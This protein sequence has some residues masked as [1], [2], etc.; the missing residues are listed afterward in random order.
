[1]AHPTTKEVEKLAGEALT[2]VPPIYADTH[3]WETKD[4]IR[5]IAKTI[6]RY[7]LRWSHGELS[8]GIHAKKDELNY[9]LRVLRSGV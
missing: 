5:I 6:D 3:A 1:M 9:A 2:Q 4:G 8:T 7:Y